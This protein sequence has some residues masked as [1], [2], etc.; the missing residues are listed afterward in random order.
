EFAKTTGTTIVLVGQVTK[1][2][3]ATSFNW[4]AD[5]A[6]RASFGEVGL[7][8]EVRPVPQTEKRLNE[9]KKWVLK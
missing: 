7:G 5:K 9:I 3:P 1:Y 8:G 6:R 2:E 4:R